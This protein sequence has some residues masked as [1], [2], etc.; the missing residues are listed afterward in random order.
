MSLAVSFSNIVEMFLNLTE[1]F[2]N[3]D[4]P[5]LMRKS[6]GT[7]Q[8][9]TYDDV[10]RKVEHFMHGLLELGLTGDSHVA[11]LSENRPEWVIADMGILALGAADVPL[12]PS[13][14][15]K[16]IE[17]ILNDA[18]C[19]AIVVSNKFQLT[20]ILK[21]REA[22]PA[23]RHIIIMTTLDEEV[24]DGVVL[25]EDVLE[26][27]RKVNLRAP[28]EIRERAARIVPHDLCTIIYTSGT[29]GNPKG[30]MLSHANFVS[31][32][33]S[34]A[35]IFPITSSDTLLSFLPLSHVFERMAG[36]Y[37]AMACGATLAYAES[38]ETVAENL[39]EV[40]PTIVCSVPRL[41]ERIYS[42]IARKVEKEPP[43]KKKIFY[44]A[45]KTAK[46][47]ARRRQR[48]GSLPVTLAASLRIADQLVLNKLRE[49]T[50]GRIRFFISGG[51]ALP[52]ELGEF[53]EAV[54]LLI[55]EGY[56]LTETSPVIA[57]NRLERYKFGSV[58]V[59]IPG[60]E[61]KIAEDGEILTRGPHVMMGYY[62]LP[63]ATRETIDADGW[64]YTGDIGIFDDEGFLHITDRKKHLFVSSGGKNI[65]PQPIENLFAGCDVVDQI[66]LIGD[67]RM[68]LTAL[69]YP[70]FE[71]LAAWAA[72][73]GIEDRSP[74]A[75]ARDPRVLAH[76]ESQI[77]D[78]QKDLA[79][80]ER[81]RK[82]HLLVEPFTV[83]NGLLTPTLKV[84]R[85]AVEDRYFTE[86]EAMY[87]TSGT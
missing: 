72:E 75:L 43:A 7:Y 47:A 77:A 19:E 2:A 58:G 15:A 3:I 39:L 59:P 24:P 32:I 1:R 66:A 18:S 73:Q 71:T 55:I 30:V 20:K 60:I 46:R 6:G 9:L 36:Y 41:F 76:V 45:V 12:Y 44:W 48:T 84:K 62:H 67:K 14:T 35:K 78:V 21:V 51:A 80:Y 65:A 40:R 49:R 52:K 16:Q 25:F 27:G 8:S 83:E 56:G 53:F 70:D 13:Q 33:S 42:K 57:A 54:G 28:G 29:T 5:M 17:F 69:I 82:F 23:L 86:I 79:N 81:V 64:L 38:V 22:L 68:Y 61:V 74:V 10:R 26:R 85:K 63:D 11:I 34:A 37:T 4:R 50:G 31:N 87:A